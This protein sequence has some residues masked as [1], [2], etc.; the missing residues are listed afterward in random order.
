ML[1]AV[2][3]R[4]CEPTWMPMTPIMDMPRIYSMAASRGLR[5]LF[6]AVCVDSCM[7][8][9]DSLFLYY[10]VELHAGSWVKRAGSIAEDE[11][12]MDAG[13]E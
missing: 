6:T 4:Y 7:K 10:A 1:A 11:V 3:P 9:K 12:H 2:L 13:T 5:G 8:R